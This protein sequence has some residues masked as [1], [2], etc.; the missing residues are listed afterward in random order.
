MECECEDL[1]GE[2]DHVGD[3]C[4]KGGGDA[5]AGDLNG[6]VGAVMSAVMTCGWCGGCSRWAEGAVGSRAGGESAV[7]EVADQVGGVEGVGECGGRVG[8]E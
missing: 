6:G 3:L 8:F 4:V 1:G 5:G 7:V 2:G